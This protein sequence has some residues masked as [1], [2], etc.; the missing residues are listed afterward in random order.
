MYGV[1]TAGIHT[2]GYICCAEDSRPLEPHV[3]ENRPTGVIWLLATVPYTRVVRESFYL[4]ESRTRVAHISIRSSV[5]CSIFRFS[6]PFP[7]QKEDLK[8]FHLN[9]D[10]TFRRSLLCVLRWA[11]YLCLQNIIIPVVPLMVWR[12]AATS[13]F[14]VPVKYS[15]R[16]NE[17]WP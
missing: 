4:H 2:P 7:V 14:P 17:K 5:R 9:G 16:W 8:S 12:T 3:R 11:C 15:V 13:L 6:K 10:C 1:Y